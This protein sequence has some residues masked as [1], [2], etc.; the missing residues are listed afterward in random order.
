MRGMNLLTFARLLFERD[1][2]LPRADQSAAFPQRNPRAIRFHVEVEHRAAHA[3]TAVG[4]VT[5]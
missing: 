5:E 3:D 2:F 4:V 1:T